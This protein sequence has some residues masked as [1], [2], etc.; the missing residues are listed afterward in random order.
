M[1]EA[2]SDLKSTMQEFAYQLQQRGLILSKLCK[3]LGLEET[4]LEIEK[5]FPQ[6]EEIQKVNCAVKEID[7]GLLKNS[8]EK[9]DQ[10]LPVTTTLTPSIA[11]NHMNVVD[12]IE[13]NHDEDVSVLEVTKNGGEAM[14]DETVSVVQRRKEKTSVFEAAPPVPDPP[15]SGRLAATPPK[16]KPPDPLSPELRLMDFDQPATTLPR[17]EPQP[18]PPDL[19]KSVERERDGKFRVKKRRSIRVTLDEPSSKLSKPPY[20]SDNSILERGSV[21]EGA[22][23]LEEKRVNRTF[24]ELSKSLNL[25]SWTQVNFNLC[26]EILRITKWA[27]IELLGLAQFNNRNWAIRKSDGNLKLIEKNYFSIPNYEEKRFSSREHLP[28]T[29]A[30]E[31]P[32]LFK[33]R[34]K[35]S[36]LDYFLKRQVAVVKENCKFVPIVKEGPYERTSNSLMIQVGDH[37]ALIIFKGIES[38]PNNEMLLEGETA[39]MFIYQESIGITTRER[40]VDKQSFQEERIKS[41]AGEVPS[42]EVLFN[43]LFSLVRSNGKKMNRYAVRFFVDTNDWLAITLVEILMPFWKVVMGSL[44]GVEIGFAFGILPLDVVIQWDP[45]ETNILMFMLI[46]LYECCWKSFPSLYSWLNFAYDRGKLWEILFDVTDH[47]LD[48]LTLSLHIGKWLLIGLMGQALTQQQSQN[49]NGKVKNDM[50]FSNILVHRVSNCRLISIWFLSKLMSFPKGMRSTIEVYW[51]M[52]F[53]Y[54]ELLKVSKHYDP[55]ALA[56]VKMMLLYSSVLRI[57]WDLGKFNGFLSKAAYEFCWRIVFISHGACIHIVVEPYDLALWNTV[58]WGY[59]SERNFVHP[60]NM[61]SWHSSFLVKQQY[62][63]EFN[64]PMVVA[65]D[66]EVCW[67]MFFIFHRLLNFVFD[68]GKLDGGKISTLRTRLFEGVG[69]DRD[70]IVKVG[71]DFG[72]RLRCDEVA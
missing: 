31:I 43:F 56:K 41:N 66:T 10:K 9:P 69:I 26:F 39:L 44:E 65:A 34:A 50:S 28:K 17:R 45:G 33:F 60:F 22:K 64:F 63:I 6:K 47:K 59:V 18:K 62:L 13:E 29:N 35:V 20:S 55:H 25:M 15:D 70:L 12:V 52:V 40:F 14:F 58:I 36:N 11:K 42:G 46:S 72:P 16:P 67:R 21:A 3:Q 2:M 48:V 57:A 61:I 54:H 37:V 53:I 8:S 32:L 4:S 38:S 49:N 19:S 51:R 71:L 1:E 68:R 23:I 5:S 24:G 7:S 27:E 30:E